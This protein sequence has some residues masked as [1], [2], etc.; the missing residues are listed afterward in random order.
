MWKI[1]LNECFSVTRYW[2]TE[3]IRSWTCRLFAYII[4]DVLFVDN[5]TNNRNTT[6]EK[7]RKSNSWSLSWNTSCK[8]SKILIQW[9]HIYY[10]ML[11]ERVTIVCFLKKIFRQFFNPVFLL[12]FVMREGRNDFSVKPSRYYFQSFRKDVFTRNKWKVATLVPFDWLIGYLEIIFN[13]SSG[14]VLKYRL[15]V[16]RH[17]D[18]LVAA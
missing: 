17:C 5:V 16:I 8:H 2:T 1:V 7:T 9:K 15:S 12:V 4:V 10:N 6:S 14:P 18:I 3:N 13:W 11:N